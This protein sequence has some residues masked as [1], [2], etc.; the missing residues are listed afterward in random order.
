MIAMTQTPLV[1]T[2]VATYNRAHTLGKAIESILQQTYRNIEIVIVDDG[3]TD[4]TREKLA[5][6]GDQVRVIS[7]KNAGPAAARN[8]GIKECKGE[9]V[10]FLDSDDLWMPTFVE[11]Q[12]YVLQGLGDDVPCCLSN[13]RLEFSDG[14]SSTSFDVALMRFTAEQGLWL[15]AGEVLAT[16]FVMFTQMAAVRR[17]ALER[18]G[19]FDETLW[20]LEDYDLA[21]KLSFEGPWGF[22]REPLVIWHQGSSDSLSQKAYA[23][24]IR[25]RQNMAAIRERAF[26]RAGHSNRFLSTR[27][28]LARELKYGRLNLV[29]TRMQSVG[30]FF[31]RKIAELLHLV[32]R[33]RM[34]GFRRS[35]WFPKVRQQRVIETE[36]TGR[37]AANPCMGVANLSP[38]LEL[39]SDAAK[40]QIKD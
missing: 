18:S 32:E 17:A 20:S 5:E 26:E 14:S 23:D 33:A 11:K 37:P 13:S 28:Q 22:I 21:L 36:Q 12:V 8:R 35:P 1:S 27:R 6:F 16:R 10:T 38:E 40:R 7:Q 39:A 25:L 3:S 31:P 24:Q 4:A 29:A 30:T 2:I 9:I 34:F 19:G 15:N